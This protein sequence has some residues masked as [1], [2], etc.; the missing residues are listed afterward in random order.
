MI[1]FDRET[2]VNLND[3]LRRE[4]LE[5]NGPGGFASSTIVGLTRL[6]RTGVE[7]GRV[8]A[9]G[10]RRCLQLC[11][12]D[13]GSARIRR[14]RSQCRK[15]TRPGLSNFNDFVHRRCCTR[16][17]AYEIIGPPFNRMIHR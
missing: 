11:A 15:N 3:A 9:C 14:P 6:Y 2:C 5:T 8:A 4:W 13:S 17:A 10:G 7:R 1:Q 16:P 12:R